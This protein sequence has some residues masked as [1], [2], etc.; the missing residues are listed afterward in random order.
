M[1]P[2]RMV[3]P[4]TPSDETG[5][6]LT[7]EPVFLVAGKL[8]RPHGLKGDILM[9]ILTDFP[10]RMRSGRELF[11]GDEHI[12]VHLERSRNHPPFLLLKF[13]DIDTPEEVGKYRNCLVYVRADSLPPLPE[14]EYYH[15]QLVGLQVIDEAGQLL[16]ILTEVLETGA[17]D[18]Y[19]VT[20]ENGKEAL[21]PAI[22]EVILGVDLAEKVMR[23]R[24][25]TWQE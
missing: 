19:V 25:Q 21:L 9:D 3:P 12:P 18:V 5:S 1:K 13:R 23:V 20:A 17:N 8:R 6:P 22:R 11:V 24:P 16:G 4:V 2:R 15:H 14:G 10:E 7:G